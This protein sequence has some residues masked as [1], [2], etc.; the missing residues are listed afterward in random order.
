MAVETS[1]P[2]IVD[3]NFPA[4]AFGEVAAEIGRS[5]V[6]DYMQMWDQ[7]TCWFPRSLWTPERVPMATVVPDCDSFPDWCVMAGYGAAL[8][9][10]LGTVISMDA[11]RRGPTELTQTMLTL[12]NVTQGKSIFQIGAGEVKQCK[13]FGWKRSQGIRRLEDFY[14]IFHAYWESTEPIDFEGNF[15]TLD[16]AWIGVA[17]GHRPQIWGLGGGPTITDMATTYADGFATMAP[18]VW[19]SPSHAA[20]VIGAMKTQLAEKGRDPEAFSFGIWAAIL[21]HE[22]ETVIDRALDHEL[23]RWHTAVIGRIIQGDWEDRD[24]IT[25]PM[26]PDWH[27]AV[28]MLPTNITA[29]QAHEWIDRTTRE[30]SEKTWIHGTPDRVARQLQEYVDVGVNWVG[31]LD[32][33]PFV[34]E[35]DDARAA[36]P[37]SLEICRHLKAFG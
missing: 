37:R 10:G 15:T 32:V 1:I 20:E 26:P 16:Q 8:A 17:K 21:T 25:G 23:M 33:L 27:Y 24:G 28:N 29:D 34:L 22:D 11:I 3:R 18:M 2:I 7:L 5:G 36:L 4:A 9:P 35:P 13:P 14:K 31:V 30:Q 19:T 6:V 12:A